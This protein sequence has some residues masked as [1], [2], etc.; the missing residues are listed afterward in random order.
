MSCA[1]AGVMAVKDKRGR[2]SEGCAY[3]Y[4]LWE[5]ESYKHR[6]KSKPCSS[7]TQIPQ[8]LQQVTWFP[9]LQSALI[10]VQNKVECR[11]CAPCSL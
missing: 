10:N 9:K 7:L 4:K 6:L 11:L 1:C 2:R 8:A 3:K 5:W